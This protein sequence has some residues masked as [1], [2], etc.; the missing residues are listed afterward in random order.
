MFQF[1]LFMPHNTKE[2]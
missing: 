2:S 1:S